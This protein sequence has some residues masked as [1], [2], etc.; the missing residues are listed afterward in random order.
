MSTAEGLTVL[1]DEVRQNTVLMAKLAEQ[2][3]RYDDMVVNMQKIA[4]TGSLQMD[5]RNLLSVAYKNV[6]GAR[7]ASWRVLNQA[8]GLVKDKMESEVLQRYLKKVEKE[9]QNLCGDVLSLLRDILIPQCPEDNH[10]EMVFYL[11][12]A[13]DYYRYLAEFLPKGVE[14]SQVAQDNAKDM[15]EQA[16]Q[17]GRANLESTNPIL[18]GLTLNFSVFHFEICNEPDAA[19]FL[20]KEGF[21]KA[22]ENLDNLPEESYKDATLIMQLLRDNL[23][24]WNSRDRDEDPQ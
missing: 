11:K 19:I 9:L 23:T 22:V 7:R 4:R 21:D 14:S 1:S 6:V 20:A 18:L 17:I 10:E 15:Y 16:V 2:S 3:E 12:M 13:G 24:L 5:E 8:E